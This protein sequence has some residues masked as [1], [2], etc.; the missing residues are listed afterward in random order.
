MGFNKIYIDA[1]TI[2]RAW[3]YN[4]AQGIADLYIKYDAVIMADSVAV[5]I[6]KIMEKEI[7]LENKKKT[8]ETFITMM[9]E[10]LVKIK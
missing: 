1:T 9:L 10:G 6:G 3:K 8:L 2:I 4:G 7:P 5:R